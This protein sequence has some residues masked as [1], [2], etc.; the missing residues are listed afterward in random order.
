MTKSHHRSDLTKAQRKVLKMIQRDGCAIC[1]MIAGRETW[2]S[3]SGRSYRTITL[4]I[5][6]QKGKL[7]SGHDGLLEMLPQTLVPT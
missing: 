1:E 7:K 3:L 6:Q 2:C 5:L 4:L